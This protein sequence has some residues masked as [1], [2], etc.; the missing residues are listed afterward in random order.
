MVSFAVIMGA[1]FRKSVQ[2]RVRAGS[3]MAFKTLASPNCPLGRGCMRFRR[4]RVSQT[5]R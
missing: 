4:C 2:I 3:G 5:E 1:E